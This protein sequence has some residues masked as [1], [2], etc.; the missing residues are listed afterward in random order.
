[1]FLREWFKALA[2]VLLFALPLS[3]TSAALAA[4][5]TR[6]RLVDLGAQSGEAVLVNNAP[7]YW[8]ASRRPAVVI[9]DGN[10]KMLLAVARQ[11][12]VRYIV[13]EISNPPE[14]GNLYQD[15]GG[16]PS[17][18]AGMKRLIPFLILL[19]LPLAAG[20]QLSP[21]KDRYRKIE[22]MVPMRDGVKLY[23]AVYVPR[24]SR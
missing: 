16:P 22:Y 8:L 12:D 18:R 6:Y 21:F 7:G 20:A 23:T 5:P 13:L 15:R 11:F 10:E 4:I 9:P 19:A 17:K 2:V 24:E 3:A 14:L 1:M